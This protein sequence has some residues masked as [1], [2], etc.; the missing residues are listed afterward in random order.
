MAEEEDITNDHYYCLNPAINLNQTARYSNSEDENSQPTLVQDYEWEEM[1]LTKGN[2]I[3]FISDGL[4]CGQRTP[5]V[6]NVAAQSTQIITSTA[7]NTLPALTFDNSG[8][9]HERYSVF[10]KTSNKL[11]SLPP[12]NST[13]RSTG[14]RNV[15]LIEIKKDNQSL[16]NNPMK[17]NRMIYNSELKTIKIKDIRIN[18]QRNI[19]AIECE[20]TF[21]DIEIEKLTKIKKLQEEEVRC[22]FPNSDILISGVIGPIDSEADLQEMENEIKTFNDIHLTKVERLKKR[23]NNELREST[24]IKITLK[25]RKLPE[26]IRI[27]YLN[28]KVRPFVNPP[29]QCYRCQRIGHVSKGCTSKVEVC[30]LCGDNHNKMHCN[31]SKRSCINCKGN[32]ASNSNLCQVLKNAKEIEKIRANQQVDYKTAR[33]IFLEEN[34]ISTNYNLNNTNIETSFPSIRTNT[35]KQSYATIV[36]N[37]SQRNNLDANLTKSSIKELVNSA[38]QTETN[39]MDTR[40]NDEIFFQKLRDCMMDLMRSVLV[41]NRNKDQEK[42]TNA[43]IE[44]NFGIRL[45]V[46]T[47]EEET[48][49]LD[50][51]NG[52][53]PGKRNRSCINQ[54]LDTKS[55]TDEE[56]VISN[57][58]S[59]NTDEGNIWMTVEKRQI[60]QRDK[61]TQSPPLTRSGKKKLKKNKKP[62]FK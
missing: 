42:I 21:T 9:Q 30:M 62:R 32:H 47:D 17:I 48:A 29:M 10:E 26:S 23:F 5:T 25:G 35:Q 22:Y 33:V 3:S 12:L 57:S 39:E 34:G 38:T 53:L 61:H 58:A 59:S 19:L 50:E 49:L 46:R 36:V 44:N 55:S 40:M 27:G 45:A 2:N 1:E 13:L 43:A 8:T 51:N 24:S 52:I 11:P 41:F 15:L 60:K 54:E 37:N 14:K 20:N 28:F 31:S 4:P 6:S 18:K 7:D 56:E 16:L